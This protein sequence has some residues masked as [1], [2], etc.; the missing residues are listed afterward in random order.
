MKSFLQV[1]HNSGLQFQRSV[2]QVCVVICVIMLMFD[3]DGHL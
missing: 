2:E 3:D 1:L